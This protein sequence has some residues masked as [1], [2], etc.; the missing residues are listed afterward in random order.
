MTS[1]NCDTL[2]HISEMKSQNHDISNI[3]DVKCPKKKKKKDD[4]SHIYEVKKSVIFM[5]RKVI[6]DK[7]SYLCQF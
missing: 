7:K 1:Q 5:R 6:T 3:Y 2:S 4:A